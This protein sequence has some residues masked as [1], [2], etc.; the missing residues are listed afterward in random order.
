[1]EVNCTVNV[2]DNYIT[3]GSNICKC[4]SAFTASNDD[5]AVYLDVSKLKVTC[6]NAVSNN[7]VTVNN[8][9]LKSYTG[10]SYNN[11]AVVYNLIGNG[12]AAENTL[13]CLVNVIIAYV[14]LKEVIEYLSKLF[15]GDV[16][17]GL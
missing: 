8:S 12:C 15:T 13:V 6:S 14:I 17:S 11:R 1:M 5:S 16:S 4:N 3:C 2:I 9:I 10:S 7:K